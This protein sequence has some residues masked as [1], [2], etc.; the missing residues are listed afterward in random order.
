[1]LPAL[2]VEKLCVSPRN[3][4]R[5]PVV[6]ISVQ[7]CE[8]RACASRKDDFQGRQRRTGIEHFLSSRRLGR[9][10]SPTRQAQ[11]AQAQAQDEPTWHKAYLDGKTPSPSMP[12]PRPSCPSSMFHMFDRPLPFV[13]A[14]VSACCV[15]GVKEEGS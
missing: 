2:L 12:R 10:T 15:V 1:M 8:S 3:A 9:T 14:V 11:Q 6:C 7:R 13:F 4:R 5:S